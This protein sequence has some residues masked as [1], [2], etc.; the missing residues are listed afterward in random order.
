M[1]KNSHAFTGS[2]S[3]AYDMIL[4]FIYLALKM[5]MTQAKFA[6]E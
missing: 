5:I 3:I 2:Y 4:L 1:Q 6:K